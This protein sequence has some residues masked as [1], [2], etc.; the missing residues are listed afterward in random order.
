MDGRKV[1]KNTAIGLAAGAGAAVAGY[2]ALV[3]INRARYGKVKSPTGAARDSLLDRFMPDP[4][5]AERHAIYV[6]APADV[7]IEAAK[8]LELM[9]SPVVRAIIRARELVLGG[10]PDTRPHPS[11]LLEQMLSIGWVVLAEQPGREVV[12]GAVTQ[13]WVANPVFRSV[14]ADEFAAFDEPD[15]VKIAWTLCAKP[16]DDRR[17]IFRTETRA[18]ATDARAKTRF[19][20]YW[21]L[22][23]P[24]VELIRLALLPS[25]K[26]QAEQRTRVAA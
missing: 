6:N 23:A 2:A 26:W 13:P 7:V 3:A 20:N 15:Y 10:E 8:D 24:G 4:E 17:S 21:S 9:K 12:L 19:R 22:V 5:V 1:L 25:V 14:P 18:R 16:I 11:H